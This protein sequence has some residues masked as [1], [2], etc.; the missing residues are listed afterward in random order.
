MR[1][2]DTLG[3]IASNF[4]QTLNYI[5]LVVFGLPTTIK[6]QSSPITRHRSIIQ[7]ANMSFDEIFDFT[8]LVYFNSC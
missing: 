2:D 5:P 1:H 6:I 8:A 3:W 4:S 7:R